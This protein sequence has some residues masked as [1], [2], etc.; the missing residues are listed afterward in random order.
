[1]FRDGVASGHPSQQRSSVDPE[2]QRKAQQRRL[3]KDASTAASV[4]N[5]QMAHENEEGLASL[6]GECEQMMNF[7]D[8]GRRQAENAHQESHDLSDSGMDGESSSD[9]E[10]EGHV[11]AR[12]VSNN[13]DLDGS[14]FDDED[15]VM[16]NDDNQ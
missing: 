15:P 1:M 11:S 5:S 14:P 9:E 6:I 7:I 12:G 4:K 16:Q 8:N 13:L 3:Q 2:Q 10:Q